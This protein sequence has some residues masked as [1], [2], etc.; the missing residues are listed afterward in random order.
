MGPPDNRETNLVLS[1]VSL[2]DM[3]ARLS[4][5]IFSGVRSE[6]KNA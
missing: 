5:R 6:K 4:G 2:P 3:A 1:V